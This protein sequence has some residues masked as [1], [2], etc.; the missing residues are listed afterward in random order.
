MRIK[1]IKNKKDRKNINKK[2]SKLKKILKDNKIKILS[3]K[4]FSFRLK[5]KKGSNRNII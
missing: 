4:C 5:E 3:L 2:I 1:L